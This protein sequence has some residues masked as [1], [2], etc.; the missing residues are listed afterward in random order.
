MANE[1][2]SKPQ[3][4]INIVPARSDGARASGPDTRNLETNTV[5]SFPFLLFFSKDLCFSSLL[6]RR[7]TKYALEAPN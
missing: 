5:P 6:S 3:P 4:L 1:M 7:P 2:A